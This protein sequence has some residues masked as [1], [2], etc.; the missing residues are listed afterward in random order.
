MST[1]TGKPIAA[2]R[3]LSAGAAIVLAALTLAGAGGAR[4]TEPVEISAE[5]DQNIAGLDQTVTLTLRITLHGNGQIDRVE[6]PR[7][8]QL[9]ALG[10]STSEQSSF[11]LG[12]GG[13]DV[14]RTSIYR[15][16]LKPLQTGDFTLSPAEVVVSGHRYR[17]VPVPI[18]ILAAGQGP[19]SRTA[20]RRQAQGQGN[21]FSAF[22]FPQGMASPFS[23]DSSEDPFA[24]IFGGAR[25]PSSSDVFLA[26][27]VDR[28]QV[29]LGQQ[30]TYSVRL[31]TR[32]DVSE[33]DDLKLPGFDGFWG[34]DLETPRHP[35]P[36]LQNVGGTAYQ[37]YLVKKKALFPS[38]A[39]S[40]TIAAA[41]VDV[42]AGGLFFRGHKLHKATNPI[43]ITVL[44]LPADAPPGFSTSNIGHW[45]LSA[46]L[47]PAVVPVGEPASLTLSAEGVGNLHALVLPKLP[48]IPG[49]RA[50]DPTS[51]DRSSVNGERFGGLRRSE[52]VL[53]GERT[54]DFKLPPM[55][56]SFFDPSTAS[57]RTETTPALDLQIVPAAGRAGVA[58]SGGQNVLEASFHPLHAVELHG[59]VLPPLRGELLGAV[60]LVPPLLW[61]LV[62]SEGEL[63]R[64]R[65]RAAP[66]Q[67]VRRAYRS[68][69]KR[70][71]AAKALL[72]GPSPDRALAE[73]TLALGGYLED[74]TGAKVLGLSHSELREQ[75]RARGATLAAAAGAVQALE[76]CEA[77]RYAPGAQGAAG[78]H[79]LLSQVEFALDALERCEWSLPR[80]AAEEGGSADRRAEAARPEHSK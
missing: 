22:G 45:R 62:W 79:D 31:Y 67:R 61:A 3:A 2:V 72:L 38:R 65:E 10:T 5:L 8:N 70:L 25:P 77:R 59:P 14:S 23:D 1:R 20:P 12:A 27:T 17:G 40:L 76:A 15:V 60:A 16:S 71:K 52:I 32:V 28:H 4:A 37:V 74:R 49:L 57:Y 9:R 41:E 55:S 43:V 33:F 34:E 80:R 30:L 39:G 63:R 44:P 66:R 58:A 56:F 24:E 50:Y 64:R 54:G 21:P 18:K 46:S 78:G 51:S 6:L 13:M 11:S 29:Y 35:M 19:S 26:G 48:P 47:R 75:L 42:V 7:S 73:I 69:R 68:A 36:T 53:I